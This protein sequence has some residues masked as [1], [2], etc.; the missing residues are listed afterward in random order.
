MNSDKPVKIYLAHSD[1]YRDVGNQHEIWRRMRALVAREKLSREALLHEMS[2]LFANPHLTVFTPLVGHIAGWQHYMIPPVA[3]MGSGRWVSYYL[4]SNAQ[5]LPEHSPVRLSERVRM[6][7]LYLRLKQ[8][9]KHQP[10]S[11]HLAQAV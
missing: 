9:V 1:Y 6:L 5:G 7:D 2:L 10:Q 8:H 3:L 4:K 11:H